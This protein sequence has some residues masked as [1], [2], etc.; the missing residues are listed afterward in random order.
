MASL[1]FEQAFAHLKRQAER[2][3]HAPNAYGVTRE[4]LESWRGK[5]VPVTALRQITEADASHILEHLVWNSF[6]GDE[7]P[8]AIAVMLM[9][10]AAQTSANSAVKLLQKSFNAAKPKGLLKADGI[11]GPRTIK[12]IRGLDAGELLNEFIVQR[13]ATLAVRQTIRHFNLS[14]AR[15]LL[16]AA[17]LAYSLLGDKRVRGAKPR[18]ANG[19]TTGQAAML[20][21]RRHYFFHAGH[22]VSCYGSFFRLWGGWATAAHVM[23][24]MLFINPPFAVGDQLH[25]PAGL[26]VCLIGC[27]LPLEEPPAPS[28]GQELVVAGYPWGAQHVETRACEAL[29]EM[30]HTD[31]RF[32]NSVG[33]FWTARIYEPAEPVVRGMSG[34]VVYDA[35]TG[36]PMG[37]LTTAN[38]AAD[39][40]QDGDSDQS[41]DFVSLNRIWKHAKAMASRV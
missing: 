32:R 34:G 38:H 13:G 23:E 16:D 10:V 9:D 1:A 14:W 27:S 25:R 6:Q 21:V 26:D 8:P 28:K 12:A 19:V 11:V 41:C 35:K 33:T 2:D 3:A 5:S 15:R 29:Y 17:R 7:L 39:F 31:L 18:A 20:D 22:G 30:D 37:I 24:D 4:M 36:T 40:D